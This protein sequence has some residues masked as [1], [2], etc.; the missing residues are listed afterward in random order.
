MQIINRSL[1]NPGKIPISISYLLYAPP[2][3]TSKKRNNHALFLVLLFPRNARGN[4]GK[5]VEKPLVSAGAQGFSSPAGPGG[6]VESDSAR[7][8]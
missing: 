1:Q 7:P 4:T 3:P 8:E 2:S 6:R 5:T